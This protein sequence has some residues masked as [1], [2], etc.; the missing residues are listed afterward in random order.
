MGGKSRHAGSLVFVTSKELICSVS[1]L[2]APDVDIT[3]N[4]AQNYLRK[5]KKKKITAETIKTL[6]D[7]HVACLAGP[8]THLC[9]TGPVLLSMQLD[10]GSETSDRLMVVTKS[11]LDCFKWL[12]MLIP[13]SSNLAIYII[14][15][16]HYIT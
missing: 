6:P 4:P 2:I 11:V 8:L 7:G 12:L 14:S 16:L 1:P 5:K 10:C 3:W 13:I 9:T 15:S